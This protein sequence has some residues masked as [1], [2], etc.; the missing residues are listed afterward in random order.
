MKIT[1]VH[2]TPLNPPVSVDING[3]TKTTSLSMCLVSIETDTG[4]VGTGLTAII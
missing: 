2:A 4:L 1:R 3:R